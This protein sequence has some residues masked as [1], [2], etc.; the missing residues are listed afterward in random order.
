[1]GETRTRTTSAR[2][3]HVHNAGSLWEL[4]T[5]PSSRGTFCRLLQ[6]I[7]LFA[8]WGER[9]CANPEA[10]P[11]S[12]GA[13]QE[14]VVRAIA[15]FP[16]AETGFCTRASEQAGGKPSDD[17]PSC[18]LMRYGRTLQPESDRHSPSLVPSGSVQTSSARRRSLLLRQPRTKT[19]DAQRTEE[20]SRQ[21]SR[22]A[23]SNEQYEF[24]DALVQFGSPGRT[25]ETT[26]RAEHPKAPL[27]YLKTKRRR[28]LA[29]ARRKKGERRWFKSRKNVRS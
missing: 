13:S 8:R 6:V 25:T 2:M 29:Y 27:P 3:L 21:F 10:L 22:K 20:I 5:R 28:V 1:V 16:L 18:I 26:R 4:G 17:P 19:E 14:D 7:G 11:W 9:K 12:N 23:L 15:L 24:L